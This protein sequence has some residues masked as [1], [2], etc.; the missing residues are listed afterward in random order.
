MA[1]LAEKYYVKDCSGASIPGSALSNILERIEKQQPISV[2]GQEYLRQNNLQA[3][4]S[5]VRKEV[6]FTLFLQLGENELPIRAEARKATLIKQKEAEQTR[7]I[8]LEVHRK[9]QIKREEILAAERH[10]RLMQAAAERRAYE[11][12]PRTIARKQARQLRDDYELDFFIKKHDYKRV[13][14]ILRR[15]NQGFRLVE[16][17]IAWLSANEQFYT[18]AVKRR[19]HEN[20]AIFY[21]TEYKEHGG[22]WSAVNACSH[23]R[24]ADLPQKGDDLLATVNKSEN[25]IPKLKSA[26]LTTHG[27]AKRDLHQRT[28][29]IELGEE[30]H[31]TTPR[32]FRPC[33]LLGA[34]H[35]ESGYYEAGQEWYQKAIERGFSEHAMDSELKSIYRKADPSAQNAMRE[36]LIKED[37]SRYRWVMQNSRKRKSNK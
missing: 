33:T 37:P 11:N 27:G 23:Y 20:E 6:D 10:E 17:D 7:L 28:E 31:Q 2:I 1:N 16:I 25:I 32:N 36:F 21:Q 4:L 15:L 13:M 26:L 12:D 19:F 3:L 30:A 22:L 29:A 8:K 14:S 18:Y 34:I 35:M 5:F 9:E 24:K